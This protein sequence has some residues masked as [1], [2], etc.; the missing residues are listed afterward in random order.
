[1][2]QTRTVGLA[3]R[4]TAARRRP[5]RRSARS[6]RAEA[7]RVGAVAAVLGAWQLS[8]LFMNPIFISTP[9]AVLASFWEIVADGTLPRAFLSSL[10]EMVVVADPKSL[11]TILNSG[12]GDIAADRLARERF[13]CGPRRLGAV[14]I[15]PIHCAVVV[16]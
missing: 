13:V 2:S 9:A 12:E 3:A 16:F 15:D 6:W 11:F 8:G 14:R 4:E 1:M 10:G 7:L 5:P